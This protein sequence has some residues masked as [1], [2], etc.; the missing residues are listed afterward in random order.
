[1]PVINVTQVILM[2]GEEVRQ[3]YLVQVEVGTYLVA[4]NQRQTVK[5]QHIVAGDVML[6]INMYGHLVNHQQH[7][8]V[9]VGINQTQLHQR[10]T[11][12]HQQ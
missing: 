6:E 9:E 5:H 11:V 4:L 12:K 1:M 10:Q 8:Q 3:V 2:F 7:V